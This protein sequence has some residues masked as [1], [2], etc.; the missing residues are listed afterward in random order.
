MVLSKDNLYYL[1]VNFMS[2]QTSPGVPGTVPC[3]VWRPPPHT[4][5]RHLAVDQAAHPGW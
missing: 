4:G 2:C 5:H 1:V 3:F